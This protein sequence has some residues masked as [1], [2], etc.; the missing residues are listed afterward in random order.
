MPTT[1]QWL[2]TTTGRITTCAHSWMQAVHW[3]HGSGIYTSPHT[4]GPRA[5]ND[6][7]LAIAQEISAL[8]ECRPGI[9]YLARKTK[10]SERSV[11]YHLRMLREAGLLVYRSKGTR[12]RGEG[13]QA[14]VYE[15]TIPTVFDTA[16]GIRT[17]G[18]G[19]QR[20]PVGAAPEHRPLLG[21][22]AKKAARKT[23]RRPRRTPVS[24]RTRCTPMQVGT[25][26]T[27]SADRTYSPPESKLASGPSKS[28][29]P[30]KSNRGPRTLNK[31]GRR[32]QFGKEAVTTIPW[33]HGASVPRVSW[34]LKD[35]S[36]AGWTVREVQAV[37]ESIPMPAHGVRRPSGML[38]DRLRGKAGM[39]ATMRA[40][41]VTMWEESRAAAKDRHTGFDDAPVAGPRS[42]AARRAIDEAFA[43]IREHL[44]PG[45]APVD[46]SPLALEDL[47][48]QQVVDMRVDAMKNP[49]LIFL[50]IEMR[51]EVY[52][53]RLYTNRLVDQTLA[54][55][56]I[57]ARRDTL[58]PAF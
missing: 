27:S 49:S 36:D 1:H 15:R 51:G 25:S 13:N 19:V 28:P 29:T 58:A 41:Y 31:V 20:R 22:L 39:T 45:N 38:A 40:G 21:K 24:G 23:R 8:K 26:G 33:L 47:T 5:M 17:T 18:E 46:E 52:A 34:V 12:V 3:V 53:R 43:A 9:A 44:A 48:K 10:V 37:A 50:A 11:K 6:T 54:L 32:Y 35:F 57:N 56:A 4:D 7:T 55:E 16:L 2:H 14:S 42:L 30:K